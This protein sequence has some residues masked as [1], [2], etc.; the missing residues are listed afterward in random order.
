LEKD[1]FLESGVLERC[2]FLQQRV[3]KIMVNH[4]DL[5]AVERACPALPARGG[6]T[7]RERKKMCQGNQTK[8]KLKQKVW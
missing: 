1:R 6:G 3:Q 4:H 8:Q 2:G 5:N 7:S